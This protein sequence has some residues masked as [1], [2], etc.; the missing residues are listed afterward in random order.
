MTGKETEITDNGDLKKDPPMINSDIPID[1]NGWLK[2]LTDDELW[3]LFNKYNE[4][5]DKLDDPSDDVDD[6]NDRIK[7]KDAL[8]DEMNRRGLFNKP[9]A[10]EK[11]LN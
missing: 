8:V 6:I 7:H 5:D 10:R 1:P 9:D 2:K 11:H 3:E 4:H